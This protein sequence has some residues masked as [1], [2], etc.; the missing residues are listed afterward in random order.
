MIESFLLKTKQ[1]A[2][3]MKKFLCFDITKEHVFL[4]VGERVPS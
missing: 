3:E 1:L 4:H 2:C